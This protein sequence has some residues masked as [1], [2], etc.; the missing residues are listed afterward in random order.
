[1][2]GIG[3]ELIVSIVTPMLLAALSIYLLVY[4]P[5]FVVI[6]GLVP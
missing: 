3:D 2:V 5:A 1:M 4:Q 6:G